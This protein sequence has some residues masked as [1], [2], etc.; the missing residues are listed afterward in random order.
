V[1][2]PVGIGIKCVSTCKLKAVG[3]PGRGWPLK[4]SLH[5]APIATTLRTQPPGSVTVA[6]FRRVLDDGHQLRCV[7]RIHADADAS[8]VVLVKS[9]VTRSIM[10][11]AF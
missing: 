8:A 1:N 11:S 2:A 7:G 6:A 4:C 5:P 9:W 3:A 10:M